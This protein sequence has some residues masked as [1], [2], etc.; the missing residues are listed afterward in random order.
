MKEI[1]PSRR[2][3]IGFRAGEL[4]AEELT[5][6][7]IRQSCEVTQV[8]MAKLLGVGQ[9]N[10]SRL[11]SRDDLLLST[12]QAFAHA[13]GGTVTVLVKLPR[14]RAVRLGR[15]AEAKRNCKDSHGRRSA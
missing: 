4:I 14:G 3:R 10:I 15:R 12:I 6:R 2:A 7:E 9:D 13:L 1:E 5:L 8:D 11:E